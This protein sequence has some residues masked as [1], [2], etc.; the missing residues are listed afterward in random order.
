VTVE[1]ECV[2]AAEALGAA[3]GVPAQDVR[4]AIAAE[5]ARPGERGNLVSTLSSAAWLVALLQAE[6]TLAEAT[7]TDGRTVREAVLGAEIASAAALASEVLAGPYDVDWDGNWP[8]AA[9]RLR[10]RLPEGVQPGDVLVGSDGGGVRTQ[11]RVFADVDGVLTADNV[12][13]TWADPPYEDVWL[14][15]YRRLAALYPDEVPRY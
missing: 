4:Q 15:E 13:D 11:L 1:D 6:P 10:G 8:S 9:P 7:R 2:R 3:L 12:P 5:H 14:S